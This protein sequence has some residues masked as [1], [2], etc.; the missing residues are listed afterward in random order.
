MSAKSRVPLWTCPKCGAKLVTRNMWHSW[1]RPL[2]SNRFVRVEEKVPGWWSHRLR[3][4]EPG[5]LDGQ[6]QA[7]LRDSYRLMGMQGR[8]NRS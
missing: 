6:V 2:T 1:P 3:V 8:L 4:T 5:Q 7:W